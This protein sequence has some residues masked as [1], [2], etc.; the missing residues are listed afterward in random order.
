L[1]RL[2]ENVTEQD[3]QNYERFKQFWTDQVKEVWGPMLLENQ[4]LTM[5][6]LTAIDQK[7]EDW[8][9]KSRPRSDNLVIYLIIS[10][11][12][13]AVLGVLLF[14]AKRKRA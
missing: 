8:G 4:L 1:V 12:V 6:E 13:I 11:I 7:V 2:E 9:I 14:M 5:E 10:V 3:Y